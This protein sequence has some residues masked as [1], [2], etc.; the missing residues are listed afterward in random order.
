MSWT[1]VTREAAVKPA[2]CQSGVKQPA[3]VTH[4][5]PRISPGRTATRANV[6]QNAPTGS[7][8]RTES[9]AL[10]GNAVR[11]LSQAIARRYGMPL[12]ESG[13]TCTACQ[14]RTAPPDHTSTCWRG[15]IGPGSS[16]AGRC[17]PAPQLAERTASVVTTATPARADITH[18]VQSRAMKDRVEEHPPHEVLD[19]VLPGRRALH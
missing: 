16:W 18:A 12:I 2:A 11:Q 1:R 17:H 5:I 9:T 6:P 15:A 14:R 8:R 13:P 10:R 19:R 3:C 7:P 4:A